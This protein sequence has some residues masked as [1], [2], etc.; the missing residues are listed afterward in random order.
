MSKEYIEGLRAAHQQAIEEKE[1]SFF[2][3]EREFSV[4]YVTYLLQYFSED[5]E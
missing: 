1:S 2:Y 5:Y 4:T 3:N